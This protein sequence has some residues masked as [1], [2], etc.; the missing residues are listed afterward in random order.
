MIAGNTYITV[1]SSAYPSGEI[2]GPIFP[3]P[4]PAMLSAMALLGLGLIRRRR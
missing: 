2:R 4:E 3:V 1:S